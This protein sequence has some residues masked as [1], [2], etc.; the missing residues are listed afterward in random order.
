M[1]YI[2]IRICKKKL[3]TKKQLSYNF[4][5]A[6]TQ[7]NHNRQTLDEPKNV[8]LEKSRFCAITG[9]MMQCGSKK[10]VNFSIDFSGFHN[11][12]FTKL[13][14]LDGESQGDCESHPC[15]LV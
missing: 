13:I 7:S 11:V 5:K 10:K 14:Q 15:F 2:S 1:L 8:F 4:E 6:H 3:F 12:N 9:L